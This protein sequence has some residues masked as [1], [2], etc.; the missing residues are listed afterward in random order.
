MLNLY[1]IDLNFN[2]NIFKL[3]IK[4]III[5]VIIIR[6]IFKKNQKCSSLKQQVDKTICNAG[7]IGL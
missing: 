4:I 6:P 5:I 2:N 1:N 7:S 3:I